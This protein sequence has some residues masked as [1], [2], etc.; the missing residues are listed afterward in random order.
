MTHR[1]PSPES[2]YAQ[3]VDLGDVCFDIGANVGVHTAAMVANGGTVLAVE[4]QGE[5]IP[6][7]TRRVGAIES[8]M[9]PPLGVLAV[10]MAVGAVEGELQLATSSRHPHLASASASWRYAAAEPAGTW[11][12]VRTVPMTTL[13]A[14]IVDHGL[15]RVLKVDVEGYEREVFATLDTP[16]EKI[17][18]EVHRDLP[19]LAADLIDTLLGLSDYEF[20]VMDE[21][22]WQFT[23]TRPLSPAEVMEN[24][25]RWG[26]IYARRKS[27]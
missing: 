3:V 19:G 25:P 5:L 2:F 13:A 1:T 9:R 27:S 12:G 21:E 16:I 17:L 23:T 6:E 7:I 20:R 18:V 22:S 24:L 4:P 10:P 14:L 15:P 8:P 26:D 11:D